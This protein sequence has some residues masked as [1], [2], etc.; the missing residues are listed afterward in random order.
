MNKKL[1]S[2]LVVL[3]GGFAFIAAALYWGQ[4]GF[5]APDS[6]S[7]E[8]KEA[9]KQMQ[10]SFDGIFGTV[11]KQSAQRGYKVYKEV[12]ASC[13]SMDQIAFRNL[14]GLGLTAAQIKALAAEYTVEEIGDDGEMV[15]R[16]ALPS[17]KLPNPYPNTQAAI[18]ANGAY[19]PDLSLMVK[20][21][22][23]GANYLYSLLTGYNMPIPQYNCAKAKDGKCIKFAKAGNNSANNFECI[24]ITHDKKTYEETCVELSEGTYYNPYFPGRALKMRAPVLDGQV[25]YDD[26]TEASVEQMAKD[27]TN[28]LQY[29]AEPEMEERKR[30]GLK[31]II[32]LTIMT[33]FFYFAKRNAWRR[34]E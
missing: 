1:L 24:D 16:A 23:D 2:V 14:Q 18:A 13:H 28:F 8:Y 31:V 30:M 22:P 27:V 19:P 34:V 33:I 25:D 20:A 17:D 7:H 11:D 21:R 32:F 6:V 10:W 9:N 5:K 29:T 26:G 15:D 4:F 12:C 3:L